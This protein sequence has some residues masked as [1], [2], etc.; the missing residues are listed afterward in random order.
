MVPGQTILIQDQ[1][2]IHDRGL[3]PNTGAFIYGNERNVPYVLKRVADVIGGTDAADRYNRT[4]ADDE[5][6]WTMGSAF[7]TPQDYESR[8][9][10]TPIHE[11]YG[12]NITWTVRGPNCSYDVQYSLH[13]LIDVCEYGQ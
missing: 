13:R 8:L 1:S 12:S 2:C 10:A 7:C 6:A 3:D 4:I 9:A 11:S 5:L